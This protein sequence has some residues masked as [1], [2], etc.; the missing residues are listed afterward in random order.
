MPD[1]REVLTRPSAPPDLTFSYGPL[2]DHVL[3]VR[4]P[5]RPPAPLVVLIHGGFW[6]AA[7]D[8]THTGPLASALAS[9]GFVVAVPE[10]RRTGQPG[11]GWPGTFEDVAAALDAIP[12]LLAPYFSGPP[13]LL[14]HSAGGHLALWAASRTPGLRSVVSLA[15]CVDLALCSTLSLDDGATDLLMGGSPDTVPDR[16]ALA[17]PASLPTPAASVLLL[18]GTADDRVPVAVSRS[19]AA[20]TGVPLVELPDAGHFALIDPLS[21]AWPSVLEAVQR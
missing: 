3:D 14:G 7:Y 17:D 19:Y 5:P 11:G 21:A 4:L 13:S 9:A 15:G 6:R 16:Y 10:Y 20:R 12:G 1:S 18:H 2:P 8:R